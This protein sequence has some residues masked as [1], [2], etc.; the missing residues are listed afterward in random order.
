VTN[1]DPNQPD[2]SSPFLAESTGIA[3]STA[4][5][6][7]ISVLSTDGTC[8]GTDFEITFGA[9]G[10]TDDVGGN[11]VSGYIA[12]DGAGVAL[13]ADWTSTA[14][15][16]GTYSR[17]RPFGPSAGQINAITTRPIIIQFYDLTSTPPGGWNTQ[18][19]YDGIVLQGAPLMD[20][21]VYDPADDVA[22][23]SN[24]PIRPQVPTI[25]PAGV[26]MLAVVLMMIGWMVLRFSIR[27][28]KS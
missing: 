8:L 3:K 1:P 11:D 18:A 28:S 21:L 7:S 16:G 4:P 14:A 5:S 2:Q 25:G 24:L 22:D 15:S 27:R 23:C 9:T 13:S 6:L 20:T 10:T 12:D 19:V 26:A 17:Q